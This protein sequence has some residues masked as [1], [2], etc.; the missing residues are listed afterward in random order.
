MKNAELWICKHPALYNYNH[1][2]K[3]KTGVVFQALP[4]ISVSNYYYYYY[5]EGLIMNISI[6]TRLDNRSAKPSTCRIVC[7][8]GHQFHVASPAQS[9]ESIT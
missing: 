6:V 7:L 5:W 4:Y 3:E 9:Q 1:G 8:C 2:H